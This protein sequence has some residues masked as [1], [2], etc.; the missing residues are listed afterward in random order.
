MQLTPGTPLSTPRFGFRH[1]GLY[2]GAGRVLHYGS[3]HRGWR[4]GPIEEVSLAEF[5]RGRGF[6][7]EAVACATYAGEQA[8]ARARSRLGEHRWR[9]WSNNCEHFV[10]WCLSGHAV[11][12][13]VD[14]WRQRLSRAQTVLAWPLRALQMQGGRAAAQRA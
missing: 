9:L 13:Q 3:L 5:A 1:H 4:R 14:A 8:V 2:A 11:S 7:V 12:P 10:S 6:A